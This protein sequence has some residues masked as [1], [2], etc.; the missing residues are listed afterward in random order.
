MNKI[1]KF[2]VLVALINCQGPSKEPISPRFNH[3]YLVVS[4]LERSVSFYTTAFDLSVSKRINK[5]SRENPDGTLMEFDVN[6]ALLKFEGQN[7]V[8]EI[9]EREN[10]KAINDSV[11]YAHLGVDVTDIETADKR[12]RQAGAT[13]IREI[14]GVMADDIVAKN[15]FYKGPDGET[16]ELMELIKGTF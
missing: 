13:V 5:I 10:F 1:I 11:S 8:L 2:L 3:V 7:F 15:S 6:M 12:I 14:Q 4:D 16:I 9:S